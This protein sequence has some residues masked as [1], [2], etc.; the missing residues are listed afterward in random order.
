MSTTQL[1]IENVP[2]EIAGPRITLQAIK[3]E[4]FK[5]KLVLSS[6]KSYKAKKNLIVEGYDFSKKYNG[7][8]LALTDCEN[9]IVRRCRFTGENLQDVLLNIVG[10]RTKN[11]LVEYCIF[12]K[13]SSKLKNGA[14]TF[15]LGESRYSGCVYDVLIRKCIFDE[16]ASDP[17]TIS[18]KCVD[19]MVEDCY[20]IDNL[21]N[22]TTRHGGKVA[23][24]HNFFKGTGGI[25]V[26]GPD[27]LIA[28]NCFEDNP[29]EDEP[30]DLSPIMIRKGN[31]SKDPNWINR[32]TPLGKT[33]GSHSAYAQVLN[34]TIL[35]NEFKNCKKPLILKNVGSSENKL[36]ALNVVEKDNK[37][38]EKFTFEIPVTPPEPPVTATC[39]VCNEQG[40]KYL[41]IFCDDHTQ[42]VDAFV[43]T[44]QRSQPAVEPGE[45]TT[46]VEPNV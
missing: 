20:F 21:S 27:V 7:K 11:V 19:V 28:Y 17:E 29:G 46:E 37:E 14:E 24:T 34:L 43:E 1:T 18:I 3:D 10:G 15:R 36:L 9:L 16:I 32:T 42:Q 2:K 25:R 4:I 23:I 6:A 45:P 8:A 35:G 40:T 5:K 13:T 30:I 31:A 26:H 38:V 44:L 22:V 41:S 33:G 39:R 12:E